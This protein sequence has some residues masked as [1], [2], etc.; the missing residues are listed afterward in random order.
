M[1]LPDLTKQSRCVVMYQN[2]KLRWVL[3]LLPFSYRFACFR[4]PDFSVV[5]CL[6]SAT[7]AVALAASSAHVHVHI[8]A[9]HLS[10]AVCDTYTSVIPALCHM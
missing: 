5:C 8:F 10:L 3:V 4:L 7:I 2:I 1:E 6:T 9:L